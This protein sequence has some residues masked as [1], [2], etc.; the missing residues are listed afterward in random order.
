MPF[1]RPAD[2]VVIDPS[3]SYSATATVFQL[4][5]GH[6][7]SIGAAAIQAT[8]LG[9]NAPSTDADGTSR[10][11]GIGAV[12]RIDLGFNTSMHSQ[13][14]TRVIVFDKP[15]GQADQICLFHTGYLNT[16][17]SGGYSNGGGVLF[18]QPSGLMAFNRDNIVAI[19]V[20]ADG[21]VT[22]GRHTVAISRNRTTG[23]TVLAMDG[24]ILST[25]TDTN[26]LVFEDEILGACDDQ[27]PTNAVKIVYYSVLDGT[28]VDNAGLISLTSNPAQLIKTA[29]A[30]V[31]PAAPTS[32]VA[33]AGN[34]VVSVA[35]TMGNNG[36]APITD[37]KVTLSNGQFNNGATSPI[38]VT[39]PNGTAV[40]ATVTSH[41]TAG[42][43]NPSAASNSV[44]PSTSSSTAPFIWQFLGN[45]GATVTVPTNTTVRYGANGTYVTAVKSGTFSVDNA[46]FTDPIPG[47]AKHAD[48]YVQQAA[49]SHV[50]I[51]LPSP[52]IPVS[53]NG[54]PIP[55]SLDGFIST[56][57]PVSI[58]APGVTFTPATFTLNSNTNPTQ[59]VTPYAQSAGDSVV[60]ITN[61]GGL[62]N[63]ADSPIH[64]VQ[65]VQVLVTTVDQ[66]TAAAQT[67]STFD[68]VAAQQSF[69]I[70][71]DNN[72]TFTG[73][74]F[75]AGNSNEDYHAVIMPSAGKGHQDLDK[76]GPLNYGTLGVELTFP[77][78]S[79]LTLETGVRLRGFRLNSTAR[80]GLNA[81]TGNP[82]VSG[83]KPRIEGCKVYSNAWG[84]ISVT[85]YVNL[86]LY[87]NLIMRNAAVGGPLVDGAW[88]IDARRN[89]WVLQAGG[90]AD[91]AHGGGWSATYDPQGAYI[92]DNVYWGFTNGTAT[93]TF[94]G[95][96]NV[97]NVG[98]EVVNPNG[99]G[100]LTRLLTGQ[101]FVDPNSD[102]RPS[103]ALIG[104][105]SAGMISTNDVRG[106]N[107]GLTP[108]LGSN[109][110]TAAVPLAVP[111]ITTQNFDNNGNLLL[112]GTYTGTADSGTAWIDPVRWTNGVMRQS[113]TT[114]TINSTN[115]TWAAT[116]SGIPRENYRRAEVHLVNSG[117][118]GPR[119]AGGSA[120]ATWLPAPATPE[121]LPTL[122]Q[123]NFWQADFPYTTDNL[124]KLV[125][126]HRMVSGVDTVMATYTELGDLLGPDSR[127]AS[128]TVPLQDGDTILVYP[129]L[130]KKFAYMGGFNGSVVNNITVRGITV[131][132]KRPALYWDGTLGGGSGYGYANN[133]YAG[134]NGILYVQGLGGDSNLW[135]NI[136][137]ISA[138]GYMARALVYVENS[139]GAGTIKFSNMRM[140]G[141]VTQG[142]NGFMS[143]V[144][145]RLSI[146]MEN[147]ESGFH[148]GGGA[149]PPVINENL[150]HGFYF[151]RITPSAGNTNPYIAIRGCFFHNAWY[152]HILKCR[153]ND[154]LVEGCYLMGATDSAFS[155][156]AQRSIFQ[157]PLANM[158]GYAEVANLDMPN[159]GKL[160]FRNNIMTKS[161]TGDDMG[162]FFMNW[163]AESNLY[164][165]SA[166]AKVDGSVDI[167][168]NTFV[169][170]SNVVRW[171]HNSGATPPPIA[172]GFVNGQDTPDSDT[173]PRDRAPISIRNNVYAGLIQNGQFFEERNQFLTMADINLP[174]IDGGVPFSPKV[175]KGSYG[176]SGYGHP[177]YVHRAQYA[178]RTDHNM[179]AVGTQAANVTVS[180]YSAQPMMA[181]VSNMTAGLVAHGGGIQY[182][183]QSEWVVNT[184]LTTVSSGT[185]G[186]PITPVTPPPTSRDILKQPFASSSIWNTAIGSAA[187]YVASGLSNN[188][189]SLGTVPW[190]TLDDERI[191]LKP[192]APLTDV[193][194]SAAGFSGADRT[195]TTGAVV[196]NVPIP[197]NVVINS[198]TDRSFASLLRPD[199]RTVVQ[200]VPFARG[201]GV[202][203]ATT[204]F[205]V[206]DVDLYGDGIT[207]AHLDSG[208]SA[209]GGSLRIG[210]LR[211][212]GQGPRHALKFAVY[213]ATDLFKA[214]TSTE[215]WRWPATNASSDAVG[216]YGVSNNNTHTAMRMGSLLAIP[217]SVNLTTLGLTTDPGKQFAWTLQNY[218][219]YIV[220]SQGAPGFTLSVEDGP[221]G[222]F[223]AQFL[224]DYG[225]ALS[226]TINAG[227]PSDAFAADMQLLIANLSVVD[228]NSPSS[229]G[230]G[231]TPRQ[232]AAPAITAPTTP[233]VTPPPIPTPTPAPTV[234]ITTLDNS[235]LA[236]NVMTLTGAYNL[237]SDPAGKLAL[238]AD[239]Q[240]TGTAIPMP[241][242]VTNAGVWTCS[243]TVPIGIFKWRIVATANS[244][245]ATSI[246]AVREVLSLTNNVFLPV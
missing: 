189:N 118:T 13:T 165:L 195:V 12:S 47:T 117:G 17:A 160:V 218:G 227:T 230:G 131:G 93:G 81:W 113:A 199:G 123:P 197:A 155:D 216:T 23:V 152:G 55:I 182:P 74:T 9:T 151:N 68:C 111:L 163:G 139:L 71:I 53:I 49:A 48:A 210:E 169:A 172:F 39:T 192:T 174:G 96:N 64:A 176:E 103:T 244:Q 130:Y 213:G 193:R 66:A 154:L 22:N 41:N 185:T 246:T 144:D 179:G 234:T 122:L 245:T 212:G 222:S 157:I 105:G 65:Q 94:F 217:A 224:S 207:G 121:A 203:Y 236:G 116:I 238:F 232:P 202:A 167:Y 233:P 10:P 237:Q 16:T 1:T 173:W 219:A 76:T 170:Y 109:Q 97:T 87:D 162:L 43:S 156:S 150:Q 140:M 223:P 77:Q 40:T 229:I 79:A 114:V 226:Q 142:R 126:H 198:T 75:R 132:G 84:G 31:A 8:M 29:A 211:P 208:L 196:D 35:F 30:I 137:I 98:P 215:A 187:V 45:E 34:G 19:N 102:Y 60:H 124:T 231:G 106:N 221:D 15:A 92:Y 69:Y 127:F 33:T 57:V 241:T 243:G 188:P 42:D 88:S 186:T 225:F 129:G 51:S 67:L 168:N 161:Y 82:W 209:L 26:N 166:E 128:P 4:T 147:C 83:V 38:V 191:I 112:N 181:P 80:N 171:E 180:G 115:H 58:S 37:N 240:P 206:A 14:F 159:G 5:T 61:T 32:V 235:I 27:R 149:P 146:I 228:N 178:T 85:A 7:T 25:A 78:T 153:H 63:P 46:T 138:G 141:S 133:P 90:T 56:D 205:Q 120:L 50:T 158:A 108:D 183:L 201:A 6:L 21:A 59:L 175:S 104:M 24:V 100:T 91:S 214:T 110:A 134:D 89:T 11:S 73:Q 204:M 18:V 3:S 119:A 143:A 164:D 36:G 200:F 72:L 135:D 95:A 70:L 28:A 20:T 145:N 107:R 177:M 190:P 125:E 148:G 184:T 194:Y 101:Y 2:P 86:E 239:P 54:A 220:D 44:T 242:V 136:D 62:L 99:G 52:Y